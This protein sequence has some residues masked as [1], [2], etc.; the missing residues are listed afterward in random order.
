MSSWAAFDWR[1]MKALIDSDRVVH[2]GSVGF[3]YV[4]LAGRCV[5]IEIAIPPWFV[6]IASTNGLDVRARRVSG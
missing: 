4:D 2:H 6:R 1:S 5:P 3:Y